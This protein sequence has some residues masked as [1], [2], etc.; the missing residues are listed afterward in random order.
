LRLLIV[1]EGPDRHKIE[2][3][4]RQ[5]G[6]SSVVTLAGQ[7]EDMPSVY[8]TIDIFALPSLNEGLPMTLL[9]AMAASRPIIATRV[10]AV[11]KVIADGITGLLVDPA[12][13]SSLA[14]AM[15]QLLSDPD[16]CRRLGQRAREHVERHYTAATMVERYRELYT[17]AMIRRGDKTQPSSTAAARPETRHENSP[18]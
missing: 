17:G 12:D 14:N 13:E 16:L 4:V 5:L 15:S 2:A 11:P 18:G 7:Q 10:G 3:L 9:E 8:R 6:L 1:G